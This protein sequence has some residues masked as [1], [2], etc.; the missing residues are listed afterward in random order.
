MA[1]FSLVTFTLSSENM[2]IQSQVNRTE[3]FQIHR[4]AKIFVQI[5]NHN[6]IRKQKCKS[7]KVNWYMWCDA[8]VNFAQMV[9]KA[10]YLMTTTQ[11]N[12]SNSLT[13]EFK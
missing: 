9:K 10:I 1:Q 3:S 11:Y 4:S 13:P 7:S 5:W 2:V 6:P 12:F 8:T